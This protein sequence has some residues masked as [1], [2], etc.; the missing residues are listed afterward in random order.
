MLRIR[1]PEVPID[2]QGV[3]NRTAME[4]DEERYGMTVRENIQRGS[5]F[6]LH[7]MLYQAIDFI[8]KGAEAVPM[9]NCIKK[10]LNELNG[11]N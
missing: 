11:G 4:L 9:R 5:L 8:P 3:I 1:N 6:I 7:D 2:V 10:D